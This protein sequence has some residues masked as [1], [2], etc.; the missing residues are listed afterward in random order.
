[1]RFVTKYVILSFVL[2][3]MFVFAESPRVLAGEIKVGSFVS[4]K[5]FGSRFVIM[6]WMERAVP[7][8]GSLKR[9]VGWHVPQL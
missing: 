4:A 7:R 3:S 9:E 6:P 1:M 2:A 5:G 8:N